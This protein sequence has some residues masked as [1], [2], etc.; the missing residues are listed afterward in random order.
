MEVT[1]HPVGRLEWGVEV[2]QYPVEVTLQ[3]AAELEKVSFCDMSICT[4]CVFAERYA[5]EWEPIK[6]LLWLKEVGVDGVWVL[7]CREE[8]PTWGSG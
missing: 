8:F 4:A 2:V 3:R 7:W 6:F 1:D 5:V